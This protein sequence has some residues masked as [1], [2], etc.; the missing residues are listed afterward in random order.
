MKF[1]GLTFINNKINYF[2]IK[3]LT[4]YKRYEGF[5]IKNNKINY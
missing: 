5:A 3:Y 4:S 1:E 2:N